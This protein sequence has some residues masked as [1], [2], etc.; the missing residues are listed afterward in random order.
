MIFNILQGILDIDYKVSQ[1]FG[2]NGAY[3]KKYGHIGHNGYDLA[4][5]FKGK[6]YIVYAP[7]DGYVRTQNEGKIGYGMYVEITGL[8]HRKEGIGMKSDMGHLKTF[9]VQ[10]GQYIAAG[11]P[12]GI[13]GNTGDSSGP[14][15][16]HTYKLCDAEGKTINKNNGFGGALD[17][18]KYIQM[19]DLARK[20]CQK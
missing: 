3:Y 6:E 1:P 15:C 11:D 13:L 4:P 9:L 12:I 10:N 19:W 8:P 14:H 7:H 18:G 20:L 2:V 16:H 17:I 5:L